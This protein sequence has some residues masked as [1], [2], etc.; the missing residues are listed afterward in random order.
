MS[1]WSATTQRIGTSVSRHGQ[2]KTPTDGGEHY[3]GRVW[4]FTT[5]GK[6][7]GPV[8]GD[9]MTAD[10]NR[11]SLEWAEDDLVDSYD[12]YFGSTGPLPRVGNYA[13]ASV[14]FD[15]LAEALGLVKL[16]GGSTYSWRVDCVDSLGQLMTTGDVWSFT[17]PE[18]LS[19]GYGIF[20]DFDGY[21]DDA[22][23]VTSW[24]ATSGAS[25]V[26]E[27][28]TNIMEYSYD[29]SVSPFECEATRELGGGGN[30]DY[31]SYESIQVNFRGDENNRPELMRIT[32]SDGADTATVY[33][34]DPQAVTDYQWQVWDID[35]DE[36]GNVDT[37]NIVSVTIGFGDGSSPGG[38][39]LVRFNDILLYPGRCIREFTSAGDLNLDCATDIIDFV[40]FAGDWLS[41]DYLVTAGA[42]ATERL[43]V[44]Y[45]FDETGGNIAV[46]SSGRGNSGMIRP[47]EATGMWGSEGFDGGCIRLDGSFDVSIGADVFSTA[48]DAATICFWVN[49]RVED[50]P[51]QVSS[52]S[53]AAGGAPRED[54]LWD[55]LMW[56]IDGTESYAGQWN[57]YAFVTDAVSGVMSIYHN[58]LL[59][60]RNDVAMERLDGNLSGSSLL[61]AGF[62]DDS[63][64]KLDDLRVYDY[65]LT[66]SEILYLA[67][68]DGAELTQPVYPVLSVADV[69]G[70]GIVNLKDFA[71]LV[72]GWMS[73]HLWPNE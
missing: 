42:P 47:A 6:A 15:D 13:E 52:V 27:E 59:V 68:G 45:R 72:K 25:V 21:V 61:E 60:A 24:L 34:D 49:G 38:K 69:D 40:I 65:A 19:Q 7:A 2:R 56:D 57:H 39:G 35:L 11:R 66:Q 67:A 14:G 4:S 17:L 23:L 16:A 3:P 18:Y 20:E 28:L 8:P 41:A 58:G 43:R 33:H 54:N 1:S 9:G 64:V 55:R 70:D 51:E 53:F 30:W 36:F 10:A 44:H 71:V 50:F 26:L 62:M 48:T 73:E 22:D 31:D 63:F 12:V 46:D 5:G 37:G 32:L 29:C